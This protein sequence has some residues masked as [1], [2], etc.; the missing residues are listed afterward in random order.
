MG[1]RRRHAGADPT[2][3][4]FGTAPRA[5][6]ADLELRRHAGLHEPGEGVGAL[7]GQEAL[8]HVLAE[9]R[10]LPVAE[11]LV[12]GEVLDRPAAAAGVAR[13]E[14][15]PGGE[16]G[17]PRDGRERDDALAGRRVAVDVGRDQVAEVGERVADGGE[18][19]VE[20]RGD[21]AGR[22]VPRRAGCRPGSRRGRSSPGPTR[23]RC[24]PGARPTSAT[25]GR[26][27]VRLTSHRPSEPAHLAGAG[28]RPAGRSP[29]ARRRPGSIACSSASASIT[30]RPSARALGRAVD[31]RRQRRVE[32]DAV[33]ERHQV[34]RHAEHGRRR[35]RPR[36]PRAPARRPGAGPATTV[37]SRTMSWAEGGRG[38][39]RWPAQHEARARRARRGRSGSSGRR[40]AARPAAGR[41]RSRGRRRTP[42][43][44]RQVERRRATRSSRHRPLGSVSR[45][46]RATTIRC[47]SSGPSRCARSG[48]RG[49]SPRAAS[50]RRRRA[51]RGSARRGR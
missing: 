40:R 21:P 27:R 7:A 18:L 2:P 12:P 33:G 48:R 50:R 3:C 15:G 28:T 45:I 43:P 31:R 17:R 1:C 6:A 10:G 23:A 44:R 47:T 8:V 46:L 14:L 25:S 35:R 24:R 16:A 5:A 4:R 51:R 9:D 20:D 13:G 39:G 37:L 26:S 30:S 19:P 38:G 41:S 32:R 34:E 49:T 11:R 22:V 29:R 42:R 36:A